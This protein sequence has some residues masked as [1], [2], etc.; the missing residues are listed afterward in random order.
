MSIDGVNVLVSFD[1]GLDTEVDEQLRHITA[2]LDMVK[3]ALSRPA[4]LRLHV[5][6][7]GLANTS[8]LNAIFVGA[9]RAQT[10]PSSA[11]A[12]DPSHDYFPGLVEYAPLSTID[13]ERCLAEGSIFRNN[14]GPV[15][16]ELGHVLFNESLLGVGGTLAEYAAIVATHNHITMLERIAGH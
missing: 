9:Y 15:T 10:A 12:I 4:V 6:T 16:H 7:L 2:A 3:D 14:G 8:R 1:R 13:L 11:K 5:S